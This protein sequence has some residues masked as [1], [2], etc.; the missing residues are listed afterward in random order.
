MANFI[1][2]YKR[3]GNFEGKY[4]N[5]PADAGGETWKG[6]ARKANPNWKGWDIVDD[7]R[8]K[9]NFPKSL[10][11]V[12]LLESL[13]KSLYKIKYW[14]EIRGDYILLQPVADSLYDSAVNM[15]PGPAIKLAQRAL[16]IKETGKMDDATL[17]KLNNK[18]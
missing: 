1:K 6:I 10:N 16:K 3:T 4:S 12:E 13:V 2:A 7:Y 14:D 15:G 8:N 11:G 17:N 5:D 9:P 18:K